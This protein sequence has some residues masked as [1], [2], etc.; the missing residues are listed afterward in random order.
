MP[1]IEM[2]EVAYLYGYLLVSTLVH[3]PDS[4]P[5]SR[6]RIYRTDTRDITV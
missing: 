1:C 5:N 4:V 3:T 2:L 6:L